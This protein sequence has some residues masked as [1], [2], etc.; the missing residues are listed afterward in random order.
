VVLSFTTETDG[1]LPGGKRLGAA[2][3]EV[4]DAT[5]GYADYFMVNCAHPL[6]FAGALRSGGKWVRRI[7]GLRANASAKSHRELDESPE[8]DIGDVGEFAE[9]HAELLPVLANLRLVGGCC[10]TDHRHIAALCRRCL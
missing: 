2:I 10:G 7:G 8:I 4:D 9:V 1:T 5:G 6:H 3:E